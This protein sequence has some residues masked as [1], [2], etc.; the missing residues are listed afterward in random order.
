M[1]G[2]T[3]REIDSVARR[4]DLRHH[5]IAPGADHVADRVFERALRIATARTR[6][7]G[8]RRK[9][10][11]GE[12]QVCGDAPYTLVLDRRD[13]AGADGADDLDTLARAGDGDVQSSPP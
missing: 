8:Q 10:S 13:I 12:V 3:Y 6:F 9:P 2:V 5:V 7:Q 1:V 4:A 11:F